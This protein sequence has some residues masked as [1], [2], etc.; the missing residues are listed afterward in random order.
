VPAQIA[1]LLALTAELFD[2]VVLD[3]MTDAEHAVQNAAANIPGDV[4]ARLESADTLRDEDR[5]TII[6]IARQ[7]LAPFQPKQEAKTQPKSD[8]G[9]KPNAPAQPTATAEAKS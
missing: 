5:K 9:S 7:A 8:G 1:V 3:R 6:E 4:S 2:G